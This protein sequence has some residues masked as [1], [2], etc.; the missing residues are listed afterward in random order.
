LETAL[1]AE[2]QKMPLPAT[3]RADDVR[4]Y[5][6]EVEAAVYFVCLEALQNIT[7]H[8]RA[9]RVDI[10]LH[11]LASELSFEVIDDGAG[12]E[13]AKEAHG[14][15]LRN[16]TDR[17]EGIGGRLQIQSEAHHGTTVTGAVPAGAMEAAS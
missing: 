9:S 8:A 5:S 3:V 10:R 1:R 12:F 2:A 13:L 17:I 16:M 15:G 11:S 4:R 7:K 14:S 6:P